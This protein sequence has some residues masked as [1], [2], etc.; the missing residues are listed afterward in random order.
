M[1]K[2][3]FSRLPSPP[4]TPYE[5][6]VVEVTA[7]SFRTGGLFAEILIW[8]SLD[9]DP[10]THGMREY[11]DFIG[12]TRKDQTQSMFEFIARRRRTVGIVDIIS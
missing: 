5:Y 3:G 2:K 9:G 4:K 12:V 6:G 1:M 10:I 11:V 7:P 8:K